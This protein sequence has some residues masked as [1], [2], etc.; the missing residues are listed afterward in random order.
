MALFDLNIERVLEHWEVHHGVRE[1]I[2]NA[3]DEQALTNTGMIAITKDDR[4]RWHI[5]DFG[6]GL[7]IE[8]FTLNESPE[9]LSAPGAVIGKFGVGLKDALATLNRHDVAV[10]IRSSAGTFRIRQAAKTR[11]RGDLDASRRT[12][13][14]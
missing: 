2:A 14:R 4:G 11:I 10:E 7:R 8:H 9:K 1:L 5:R 6:R 12:R 3:L 13:A